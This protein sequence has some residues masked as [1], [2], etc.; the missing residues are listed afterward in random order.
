L[1]LSKIVHEVNGKKEMEDTQ[2]LKTRLLTKYLSLSRM[3]DMIEQKMRS[4]ISIICSWGV[5]QIMFQDGRGCVSEDKAVL[6]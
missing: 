4:H 2:I 3:L 5:A 6:E 1:S